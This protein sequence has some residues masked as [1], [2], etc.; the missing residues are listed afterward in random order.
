MTPETHH[1]WEDNSW[2]ATAKARDRQ[3]LKPGAEHARRTHLNSR[4]AWTPPPPVKH[5]QARQRTQYQRHGYTS[6][7]ARKDFRRNDK[8]RSPPCTKQQWPS[9]I[10]QEVRVQPKP[11]RSRR[12]HRSQRPARGKQGS[13]DPQRGRQAS[14][15]AHC[16][17]TG[18]TTKLPQRKPIT[19]VMR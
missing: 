14:I 13:R 17:T 1:R 11:P 10:P 3:G 4:R 9:E 12:S 5:R 7:A 16:D 15:K 18:D 2:R 19:L 8:R 6:S